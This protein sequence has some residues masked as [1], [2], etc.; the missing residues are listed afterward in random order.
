VLAASMTGVP[1]MPT[2]GM[3]SVEPVS[4]LERRVMAEARADCRWGPLRSGSCAAR[5]GAAD[6]V[7]CIEAVVL[8]GSEDN[9]V[10]Y[11]LRSAVM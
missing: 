11:R 7:E 1:V 9:I 10:E 6:L 5:G 8:R 2:I 3:D 4:L